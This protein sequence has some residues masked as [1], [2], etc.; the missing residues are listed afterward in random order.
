MAGL[1]PGARPQARQ[2]RAARPR[3]RRR[4]ASLRGAAVDGALVALDEFLVGVDASQ[5]QD[6]V[7][8][9]GL[10]QHREVAARVHR[11]DHLAHRH[12]EH[13]LVQRLVGQALEV[14]LHRLLAHQV[15]DE[16]EPHLAAHGG[17]AKDGLDVEQA[18]AAHFQQIEQQLR[19]AALD[20]G[21][22]DAEEVDRI[23]SHEAMAA[24]DQLQAQFALAQA[25]FAGQQHAQAQDVHEHAVAGGA[26]G[27]QLGQIAA[28]DVDDMAGGFRGAE[29]RDLGA[30]A[31]GDQARR[32]HG[33]IGADQHR[34]LQ[35]DD[36]RD[37]AVLD[38]DAF[39]AQV[40]DLA[41]ADDLHPVGMDV[42]QV[43]HQVGGTLRIAHR[44][45]IEAAL[46]VRMAGDPLPAQ[47]L[48]VLFEEPLRAD[49]GR[50]Q[51]GRGLTRRTSAA[52][53]PRSACAASRRPVRP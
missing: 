32:R 45:L 44:S 15:D 3:P 19:A 17:F 42:V 50:L 5:L 33:V 37:A 49:R 18:D 43:A 34:R 22:G 41:M 36:A 6:G 7:A 46:R 52:P 4:D 20:G 25:R 9:G 48:A 2:V 51:G 12:A 40:G 21:L 39:L 29:Q 10:D 35:R 31:H 30:V 26:V 47:R 8:H 16:L 1:S 53:R 14:A 38:L 13:V 23:V 28:H 11:N 24:G 27:E